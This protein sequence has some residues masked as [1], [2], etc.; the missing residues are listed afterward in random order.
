MADSEAGTE[1]L[2]D[3]PRPSS[4]STRKYQ[5]VFPKHKRM[6][7]C[8]RNIEVTRKTPNGQSWNSLSKNTNDLALDDSPLQEVQLNFSAPEYGLDL[9][10]H[11][12]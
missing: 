11:L 2:Q 5:E 9:V 10:T 8:Q 6:R 7:A 12:E 4:C 1:T 3:E